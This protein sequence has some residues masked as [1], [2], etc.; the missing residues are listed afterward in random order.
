MEIKRTDEDAMA[1]NSSFQ[2][3]EEGD[4]AKTVTPVEIVKFQG[5][6]IETS[7]NSG[8]VNTELVAAKDGSNA[9]LCNRLDSIIREYDELHRS[10]EHIEEHRFQA[11]IDKLKDLTCEAND[12]LASIRREARKMLSR[13]EAGETIP[14]DEF[15]VFLKN[16][17]AAA[18]GKKWGGFCQ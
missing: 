5:M 2:D 12:V 7:T 10:S 1:I 14:Q 18:E 16:I 17:V 4:D 13:I 3:L 11:L 9:T 15:V 8:T 6:S